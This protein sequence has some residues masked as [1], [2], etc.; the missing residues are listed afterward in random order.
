MHEDYYERMGP[1]PQD[2]MFPRKPRKIARHST[3]SGGHGQPGSR[4]KDERRVRREKR[5]QRS[6]SR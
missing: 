5:A 1:D 2:S 6:K 3:K 4:S